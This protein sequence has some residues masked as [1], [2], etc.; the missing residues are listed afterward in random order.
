MAR[1]KWDRSLHRV[2]RSAIRDGIL[3]HPDVINLLK[4]TLDSGGISRTEMQNL[5]Q[6]YSKASNPRSK[7]LLRMI[8]IAHIDFA[9]NSKLKLNGIAAYRIFDFLKGSGSSKFPHLDRDKIGVELLRRIINPG[10][11]NQGLASLCGP[12]ALLFSV[13]KHN[14]T[15]Y[16]NFAIDLFENGKGKI[17]RLFIEPGH[18]CRHYSPPNGSISQ[19][20]WMTAAAVRDSENWF[21]DYDSVK[22]AFAGITLPGEL[23]KWFRQAGFR[24][25]KEETNL[26]ATKGKRALAEVKRLHDQGYRVCL[27]V[28]VNMLSSQKQSQ[29]TTTA[30]HWVVLTKVVSISTNVEL[31]V[32][33]WGDG[34]YQIPQ[35]ARLSVNDFCKNFYGY[36]AGKP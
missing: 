8:K 27:F 29:G 12:S 13:A 35:G 36:V 23:A 34:K 4:A 26:V 5:D 16:V 20:D 10:L 1:V 30:Q 3:S 33:T 32:F 9:S 25:V 7:R 6:L 31:E 18:D 24:D 14:P 28:G 11:I 2:Y 21:F 19:V 22:D 15:E 17:G